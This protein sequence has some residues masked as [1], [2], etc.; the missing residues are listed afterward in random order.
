MSVEFE[1][2]MREGLDDYRYLLTLSHLAK[3]T[4]DAE[5]QSLIQN[6]LGAFKL[7][8]TSITPDWRAFRRE[9]AEQI[10]RLR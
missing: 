8:D 4:G 1:R 10:E 9:V 7:G 5:A 6:R 2:E 3:H